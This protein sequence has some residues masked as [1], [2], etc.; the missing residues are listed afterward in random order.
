MN[1]IAAYEPF[2]LGSATLL[3]LWLMLFWMWR[4][5]IFLRI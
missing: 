1:S 3:V 5:K 2:L 4:K